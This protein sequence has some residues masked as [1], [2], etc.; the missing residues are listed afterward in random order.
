MTGAAP[1]TGAGPPVDTGGGPDTGAGG[2]IG[3]STGVEAGSVSIGGGAGPASTGI[4]TGA[5]LSVGSPAI[6]APHCVQKRVPTSIDAPHDLL[7][8]GSRLVIEAVIGC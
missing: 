2:S 1:D 7:D 6:D 5:S 3:V 8:P 4:S